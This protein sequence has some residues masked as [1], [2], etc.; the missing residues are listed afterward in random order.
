MKNEMIAEP[1]KS[2]GKYKQTEVG[3]IPEDWMISTIGEVFK[4]KQGVQV[5]VEKQFPTYSEN[6]VQ[7]IR[8]VDVTQSD[9]PPRYIENPGSTHIIKKG[10]LFMVRYGA[11]GVVDNSF[12]GVIANNLFRLIPQIKIDNNFFL[13]LLRHKYLDIVALSSSTTMSALSFGTLKELKLQVP[14]SLSEQT[15]IAEAL[16]DADAMIASLEKLIEKKKKIKQGA[17]QELL[18]PKEG[19][20][21]RKLGEVGNII[22][23]NTPP[24]HVK[25]YWNGTIPWVTPTD[26]TSSK[27]IYTSE[28]Q[29]TNEGL[30]VIRAL[31]K[32]TLL[33]T[34]IASIGKNAIL[35]NTGSCNQQINAIIPKK[36]FDIDFLYYLI[37]L[38]KNY[39]LGNAG[40]TATMI[41][42][43]KEF[44]EMQFY[45]PSTPTQ[46]NISQTLSDLDAEI[47]I[48]NE[49]LAKANSVK[50]GMMQN[51][52][53]GKIRLV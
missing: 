51:L 2:S 44:S 19:W 13:Y 22:T 18:R 8:I 52:L 11:A 47:S 24:T 10:D 6:R 1:V 39:F 17:M 25:E 50:Q 40:I 14:P 20:V 23:G 7:F 30:E 21:K 53:T 15:A 26:I 16:S 38:N 37:E 28:R 36:D 12:S 48:I 31:P 9:E 42:S 32:D 43:K 35:R 46:K 34:C 29:V 45:F 27:D 33:V 3:M 4:F 5:P 41:I 49:K